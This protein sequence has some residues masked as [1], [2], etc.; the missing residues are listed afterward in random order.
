MPLKLQQPGLLQ[1]K[2]QMQS[3]HAT[4]K[5]VLRKLHNEQ[6]AKMKQGM[7]AKL[8]SEQAAMEKKI[9]EIKTQ[10]GA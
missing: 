9:G 4:E 7:L 10:I 2:M 8:A 5:E 6:I 3:Q 1:Q